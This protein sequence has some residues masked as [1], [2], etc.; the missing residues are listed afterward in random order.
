MRYAGA[1][2]EGSTEQRV[3]FGLGQ[4]GEDGA[5]ARGQV[6]PDGQHG[7]RAEAGAHCV[8]VLR[9]DS[10]PACGIANAAFLKEQ[11]MP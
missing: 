5:D 6:G 11:G 3:V 8:E 1:V 10:V 9:R 7:A 2:W 4:C